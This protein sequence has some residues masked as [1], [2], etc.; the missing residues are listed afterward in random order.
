MGAD[1]AGACGG[2]LVTTATAL[3]F[4]AIL[5]IVLAVASSCPASASSDQWGTVVRV[6]DGDTIAVILDGEHTPRTVRYIGIDAPEDSPKKLECFGRDATERNRALVQGRRVRLVSDV[7]D[8][9]R[10]G[11]LLRYVYDEDG[12]F[13]N[14]VLVWEGFAYTDRTPPDTA[15]AA[16]LRRYH[17]TARSHHWGVW[18]AC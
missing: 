3:M 5:G 10:F 13:I 4:A 12:S 2:A 7:R 14:G 6:L 1:R 15:H 8:T 18:A 17:T 11:R 16:Q 9:D